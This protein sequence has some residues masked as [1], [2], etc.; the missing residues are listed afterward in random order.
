[1]RKI[2]VKFIITFWFTM[3]MVTVA[4]LVMVFML[5]ASRLTMEQDMQRRI[6][7]GVRD[8]RNDVRYEDDTIYA[9]G[10]FRYYVNCVYC[11]I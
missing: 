4:V 10:G 11:V 6:V 8:N 7:D 3:L 5:T 1:M 2:S 9:G